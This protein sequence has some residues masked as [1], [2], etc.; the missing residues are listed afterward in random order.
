MFCTNS[1]AL[2]LNSVTSAKLPAMLVRTGFPA[3]SN[4]VTELR[5][6]MDMFHASNPAEQQGTT[7]AHASGERIGSISSG[8]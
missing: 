2:G 5:P 3:M 4:P 6:C 8:P 1:W 7:G